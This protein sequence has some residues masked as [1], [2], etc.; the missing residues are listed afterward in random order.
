MYYT[1]YKITNL[2]NDKIYIGVHKTS[3]LD[4]DYMGSGKLIKLSIKKHGLENFKKEYIEVFDNTTDMFNMESKLV[5][6][7][8]IDRNDT[9]NIA[10]GGKSGSFE[11]INQSGRNHLHD[12]RENSL[13][14]LEK[15]NKAFIEKLKAEDGFKD[16]WSKRISETLK[17]NFDCGMMNGFKNKTHTDE[18]KKKISEHSKKHQSGSGNSQYGT[19][20]MHSLTEKVSKKIKKDEFHDYEDLGW[21]KGRKMKFD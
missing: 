19:M 16:E 5:N 11:Y 8:F 21:I 18:T 12:N 7:E 2:I 13:R 1:V 15:G 9:Y 6:E 20:W 14:N 4:D 17:I 3:N 10:L